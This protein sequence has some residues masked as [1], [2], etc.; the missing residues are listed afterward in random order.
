MHFTGHCLPIK[1]CSGFLLCFLTWTIVNPPSCQGEIGGG[2]FL[3]NL[4]ADFAEVL[5]RIPQSSVKRLVIPVL[6]RTQNELISNREFGTSNAILLSN[7]LR[8]IRFLVYNNHRNPNSFF[9]LDLDKPSTIPSLRYVGGAKVKILIH[10]YNF[11]D[12]DKFPSETKD[13]Y[14]YTTNHPV[15]WVDWRTL[16]TPNFLSPHALYPSV[17]DNVPRVGLRVFH[18]IEFLLQNEIIS[19]PRDVHFVGH[20]LGAHI[21]GWAGKLLFQKHGVL[22]GRITGLDPAGPLFRSLGRNLILDRS[23][24]DFVDIVH[25]SLTG[26]ASPLGHVDFYPNGGQVHPHC[27][28]SLNRTARIGRFISCNHNSAYDYFRTSIVHRNIIACGCNSYQEFR[29]SCGEICAENA[30][31]G[32]FV[33]HQYG[34]WEI[35][36][37]LRS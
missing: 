1:F 37:G 21:A 15:I 12:T 27:L 31:L 8:D 19:H 36:S 2:R 26:I 18:L 34:T 3:I 25:S 14:L 35:F 4:F 9:E 30:I 16:A 24:A 23:D 11:E 17:A 29:Q 22:V 20:S 7:N 6:T 28:R 33:S 32:E 5:Q 13:A 10:G